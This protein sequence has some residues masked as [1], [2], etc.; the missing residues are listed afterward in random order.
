MLCGSPQIAR[1]AYSY[2]FRSGYTRKAPE[3]L[4]KVSDNS[5]DIWLVSLTQAGVNPHLFVCRPV[6]DKCH[7]ISMIWLQF[8]GSF[9]LYR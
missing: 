8:L 6:L 7:I 1:I 2:Y 3:S 4:R 5:L 9:A